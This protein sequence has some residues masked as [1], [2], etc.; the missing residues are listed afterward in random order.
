MSVDDAVD[1]TVDEAVHESTTPVADDTPW[2][3]LSQR[4][5]WVDLAQTVLSLAPTA[6][7]V[8]V[9]GVDPTWDSLWP[10]VLAGAL[11]VMSRE[12]G[13]PADRRLVADR[14]VEPVVIVEVQPPGQRV[15]ALGF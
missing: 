11:G 4:M 6:L 10:L 13:Q 5:I 1:K 2:M 15:A 12:V 7:A 14:A 3:R 9:F 8:G